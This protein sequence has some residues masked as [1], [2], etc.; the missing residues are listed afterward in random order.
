MSDLFSSLTAATRA[1]EAQRY[2]LDVT[3]QNIANVNTPGYSRRV[4]DFASVP[5]DTPRSAGRGV[6]VVAVR[7]TRDRMIEQRLLQELPA[8][9]REAAIAEALSV[10]ETTLGTSGKS[11]D[12]RLSEFFDAFSTLAD[13]PTS[14]VARSEVV[15][16]G[17]ALASAFNSMAGRIDASR[18]D[19]DNKVRASVEAI[20]SLAERISA[21]NH[22]IASAGPGQSTL[23]LQDQ[24][25][26][27]L[28]EL[29]GLVDISALDHGD[30]V[31]DVTYGNGRPLVVGRS[32]Y[33]LDMA[34]TPPTGLATLSS[35][36]VNVT[37]EITGGRLGGLLQVRDVNIPDYQ[38]RLDTLAFTVA[39]EV[40][41]V[42]GAG[43]DQAGNTGNAF[44]TPLATAAGAARALA[45][46]P[47]VAADTSRIAAASVAQAGD[48]GTAKALAGL[49]TTR[50]LD[51][52][53]A[54]LSDSWS[55]LVYRVGRDTQAATQE[56]ASRQDIVSQVEALRDQV[57]GV[58]LDEEAMQLMRFQRAYEAN[59]R[60]FQAIDQAL[61]TLLQ[62]LGR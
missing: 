29:S 45:V 24:Q 33:T 10:V 35:G 43:Y 22:S 1:L 34:S 21:L 7:A 5:P 17:G 8:E 28:R 14:S 16:Q 15:M 57:S 30:G 52:G 51:G 49:A 25:G 31:V 61:E 12:A 27:L 9:Q 46:D 47:A 38:N 32:A 3:G 39:T 42:H 60:F 20:N 48:N 26:E 36:G 55:R 40:N 54:T 37:A 11:I 53:T 4:V 19:A 23:H 41:A 50:V 2:A 18:R 56:Q 59:A 13:G 62:T 44:F 6:D 58:S